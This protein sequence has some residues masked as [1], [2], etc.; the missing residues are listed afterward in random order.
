MGFNGYNDGVNRTAFNPLAWPS[1]GGPDQNHARV[2]TWTR[3]RT[4]EQAL[5]KTLPPQYASAFF[6]LVG[7]PIEGSAA[8]D[9]KFPCHRSHLPRCP[10]EQLLREVAADAARAQAAYDRIQS[11]TTRYNSI[12]NGKWG[13]IMSASPR[14]RHVFE[15]PLTATEAD[16]GKP[17]PASWGVGEGAGTMATVPR[18][19]S[20]GFTEQHASV[21]INAAHFARKQDGEDGAWKLLPRYWHLGSIRRLW[22]SWTIGQHRICTEANHDRPMARIPLRYRR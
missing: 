6:E 2:A 4:D 11:L 16:S 19:A 10:P 22:I 13:G 18:P 14:E 1:N 15:M 7:Y 17:L 21:S 8:M 20:S 12:E 3:L 9:A 5:A